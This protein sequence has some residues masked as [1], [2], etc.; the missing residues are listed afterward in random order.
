MKKDLDAPGLTALDFQVV[1]GDTSSDLKALRSEWTH[2]IGTRNERTTTSERQSD[3]AYARPYLV[4]SDLSRMPA[5]SDEERAERQARFD[6][7][8][9]RRLE[10][11]VA[12]LK[13]K[14]K[15]DRPAFPRSQQHEMREAV[16]ASRTIADA[17][18]RL[19]SARYHEV[20]WSAFGGNASTLFFKDYESKPDAPLIEIDRMTRLLDAMDL[21]DIGAVLESA[22]KPPPPAAS[23]NAA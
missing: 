2:R 15:D 7:R 17:R 4:S 5:S 1:Y 13:K 6:C 16:L 22:A 20:G 18:L 11:A 12:Q 19:I 14:T 8:H 10:E 21:V 9:I 23:E 3:F